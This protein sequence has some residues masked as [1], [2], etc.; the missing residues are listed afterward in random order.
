MRERY[1]GCVA[2]TDTHKFLAG[3][4]QEKNSNNSLRVSNKNKN[5]AI[6]NVH[7]SI[8]LR[9]ASGSNNYLSDG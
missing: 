9:H 7:E 4:F 1:A 5:N 8:Y 3:K 2:T 6:Y